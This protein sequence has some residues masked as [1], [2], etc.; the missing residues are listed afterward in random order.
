MI[1]VGPVWE[2]GYSGKGVRVRIN[3]HGMD[4]TH[5]EFQ[6]RFDTLGSCDNATYLPVI[7]DVASHGTAVASIVGGSGDNGLCSVG[8]SPNVTISACNAF[9]ETI[10][11]IVFGLLIDQHDI[12]QNSF[13]LAGWRHKRSFSRN[14]TIFRR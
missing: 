13:G 10:R 9:N 6:D 8:I 14:P 5:G 4:Y 2:R 11:P 1:D 3:D 12:S 7:Q